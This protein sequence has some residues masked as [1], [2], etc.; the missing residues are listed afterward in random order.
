M[1]PQDTED[2]FFG[3]PE[4]D[5]EAMGEAPAEESADESPFG[6]EGNENPFEF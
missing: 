4:E 2:P 5:A 6:V 1:P 3:E